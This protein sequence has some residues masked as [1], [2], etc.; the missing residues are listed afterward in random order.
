MITTHVYDKKK[1]ALLKE[2]AKNVKQ[3]VNNPDFVI[4]LD[5]EMAN[6]QEIL[7]VKEAFGFHDLTLD[8]IKK[9]TALPKVDEYD[10]YLFVIF[11]RIYYDARQKSLVV[12]E[13]D[14]A[15]GKNYLVSAHEVE[16]PS[17]NAMRKKIEINPIIL[18]QGPDFLLHG[19]IDYFIDQYLPIIDLWDDELAMIEEEVIRGRNKNA[20]RKLLTMKRNIISFKKSIG[21]QRDFIDKLTRTNSAFITK[22]AVAYFKDISDHIHRA[23][24]SLEAIRDIATSTFDAYVSMINNRLAE[25]SNKLNSVMHRLTVISTVFLP[26]TFITGLYGM[27]F[28]YM[29]ELYWRWGYFAVLGVIAMTVIIMLFY[30]KKNKWM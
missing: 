24:I 5:L 3:Y 10:E 6:E 9:F 4:W 29:P 12:R 30:F 21:P 20:M 13:I 28:H 23:Y 8:D 26:L 25:T 1:K 22:K 18:A 7:L 16:F 2:E 11:H 27:N 15:L 17:I 14:F 19:N